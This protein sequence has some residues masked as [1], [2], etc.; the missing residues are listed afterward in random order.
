LPQAPPLPPIDQ[1][2]QAIVSSNPDGK[3]CTV[4]DIAKKH[5][6]RMHKLLEVLSELNLR[7]GYTCVLEIALQH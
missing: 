7:L 6:L 4:P 3:Y 5:D 2:A 1:N